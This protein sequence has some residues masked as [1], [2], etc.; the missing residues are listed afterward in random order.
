NDVQRAARLAHSAGALCY[1]DAVHYAPHNLVDVH[2]LE[3]DF[4][5]C[6]A[7]KF[8]GPHIG[9]LYGK[10]DLLEQLDVPK[11]GPASDEAP[12]RLE[13]AT[14]NQEGLVGALR[15]VDFLASLAQGSSRRERLKNTYQALH[16]R[17][18]PL[19]KRMWDG[20]QMIEGVTL[21]GPEPGQPRTPTLSFVVKNIPS[22]EVARALAERGI[23]TSHGDFYAATVA[24]RLGKSEEGLVRA[25]CVCYTSVEE[26]D[27]LIEGVRAIARG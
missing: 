24:E 27:R 11:V 23:F 12:D 3:C 1:V 22:I 15:A 7:Y 13:T 21:F 2:A 20:L 16:E 8:Y 4:L 26:V 5:V 9:V 25:G 6:S 10:H 14:K 18:E 17:G 19:L